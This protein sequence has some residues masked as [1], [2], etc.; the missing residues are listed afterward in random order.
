[1]GRLVEDFGE[2]CQMA[3][4]Q[5]SF[6]RETET[7]PTNGQPSLLTTSQHCVKQIT[8][9]T[10]ITYSRHEIAGTKLAEELDMMFSIWRALK[11]SH[12]CL[13]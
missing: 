4:F 6:R 10:S 13:F 11:I 7:T 9:L 8:S 5:L 3:D 1:L 2:S 12:F